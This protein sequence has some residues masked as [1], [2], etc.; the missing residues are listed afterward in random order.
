MTFE[1]D[2]S[3]ALRD[4]AEL[5]PDPPAVALARSAARIGHLRRQRRRAVLVTSSLAAVVLAG[6]TVAGAHLPGL[7]TTPSGGHRS[8]RITGPFMD[9]TIRAL[10]PTGEVQESRA[11]GLGEVQA[12]GAGPLVSVV[13]DDG[14]GS[15]MVTLTTDRVALPITTKTNG[16]ECWDSFSSPVEACTRTPRPDGSVLLIQKLHPRDQYDVR[17]WMAVYTGADGH[18]IRVD[19]TNSRNAGLPLTRDAPP[20]NDEQLAALVTSRL[21]DPVFEEFT[22]P[23]TPRPTAPVTRAPARPP[24]SAEVLAK[25]TAL[26]PAGVTAGDGGT[27]ESEGTAHFPVTSQGRESTLA[28]T[29]TPHW[30]EEDQDDPKTFFR[31]FADSG[32]LSTAADGTLVIVRVTGASKGSPEPALHWSVEALHPDGTMVQVNEW[33]GAKVWDAVPGTP[34]LTTD[35]LTALVTGPA[36][37]G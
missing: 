13:F 11:F 29:V 36:W 27:Q 10:L 28:V 8:D 18:Q 2:F 17:T 24:A 21:W 31:G 26:L 6:L 14:R 12:P 5:S 37:R 15:A 7:K 25:A 32:T 4:A 20:L 35:Q 23:A 33:I 16:T 19:E 1:E 34:A 9:R 3:H 22:G 30:R